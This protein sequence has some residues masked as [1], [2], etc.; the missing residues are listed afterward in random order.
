MLTGQK[1]CQIAYLVPDIRVA[2]ERHARMFGTGPFYVVDNIPLKFC[3]YRGRPTQWNHS[4]A[5]SQWGDVMIELMQQNGPGASVL[6]DVIPT[7]SSRVGVHHMAYFVKDPAAVAAS[8]A[9]EG[10]PLALH[11]ELPNGIEV[12]MVDTV[13]LCGHMTELYAPTP[14]IM[15]F[16]DLVREQSKIFD[17]NELIRTASFD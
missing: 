6:N 3:E 15:A 9:K 12:F 8:M 5:F 7:G 4:A 11:C 17:G 1:P 2:A 14:T 13:R 10:Y 16:Y